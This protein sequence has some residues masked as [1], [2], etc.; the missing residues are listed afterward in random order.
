[1]VVRLGVEISVPDDGGDRPHLRRGLRGGGLVVIAQDDPDLGPLELPDA[2]GSGENVV[3]REEGCPAVEVTVVDDPGHPG[4]VVDACGSSP[5]YPVL[6][7][8]SAAF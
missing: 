4:V 7:V 3:L 6:V 5:H 2:V 8:G 1:M